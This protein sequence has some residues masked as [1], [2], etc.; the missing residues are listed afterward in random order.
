MLPDWQWHDKDKQ[1]HRKGAMTPQE[2][3]A[4]YVSVDWEDYVCLGRPAQRILPYLHCG[5]PPNVAGGPPV[6]YL[7][8]PVKEMK[9]VTQRLWKMVHRSGWAAMWDTDGSGAWALDAKLFDTQE[10]YGVSYGMDKAARLHHRQ[11]RMTTR[12]RY[13]RRCR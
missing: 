8:I 2:F 9:E 13:G 6:V 4:E 1:F 3:L 11:T 10:L 7:N 12:C 5:L